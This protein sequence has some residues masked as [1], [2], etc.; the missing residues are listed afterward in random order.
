MP[1]SVICKECPC[2]FNDGYSVGCNLGYKTYQRKFGYPYEIS[3]ECELEVVRFSGGE[4]RPKLR[5]VEPV[6]YEV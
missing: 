2:L 3:D 4:F 5:E 1:Q 6:D